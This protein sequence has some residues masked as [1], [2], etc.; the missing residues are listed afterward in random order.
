MIFGGSPLLGCRLVTSSFVLTLMRAKRGSEF[1]DDLY[2]GTDPTRES[3]TLE[4]ISN[5]NHL[6]KAP[7][8]DST[9][10]GRVSTD[11]LSG[12]INTPVHNTQ[13]QFSIL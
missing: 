11:E 10:A 5:P 13:F 2:R 1:S 6:P 12:D 9:V 7:P 8:P 4:T 3:S